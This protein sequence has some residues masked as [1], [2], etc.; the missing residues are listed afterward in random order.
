MR[1]FG[2]A[3]VA[4]LTASAS[5]PEWV[6]EDA[7]TVLAA[8]GFGGVEEVTVAEETVTF[9]LPQRA[10]TLLPLAAIRGSAS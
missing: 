8:H 2:A 9:A 7:I 10:E 6:V 3:R 5:T 1:A 4:G